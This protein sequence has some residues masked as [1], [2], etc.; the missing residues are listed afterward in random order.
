MPEW[1]AYLAIASTLALA[2]LLLSCHKS[3]GTRAAE[4]EA[5]L[6]GERARANALAG[7][8]GQLQLVQQTLAGVQAEAGKTQ[9]QLTAALSASSALDTEVRMLNTRHGEVEV[10]RDAAITDRDKALDALREE[11]LRCGRLETELRAVRGAADELRTRAEQAESDRDRA[12]DELRL[13]SVALAEMSAEAEK[14]KELAQQSRQFV[15]SAREQLTTS[16]TEAASKVFDEKAMS[17]EQRIALSGEVSKKNLEETLRPFNE[18]L[19]TFRERV[20]SLNQSQSKDNNELIGAVSQL[21][22]LNQHMATTTENL[23]R[24]LKGNAKIRGNWGEMIL[25]TVLK[26]SGLEEGVNFVR[27]ASSKDEE[28][29]QRRQPDVVLTLP[30]GRQVV[31]DSKVNLVAWS[32]AHETEDA[33]EYQQAMLRHAAAL[34]GHVKDLSEKNYPKVLGGQ[35]LDLT[36]LF[37]PIEGA[38]SQALATDANLQTDAWKLK[39]AFATPNTLMAMLQI[40]ERL[41]MRD[42]L[43]KQVGLI[44][45][46]AGKLID[47]VTSFLADFKVIDDKLKGLQIAYGNASKRLSESPQSVLERTKRLVSAGAKGKKLLPDEL[48]PEGATLPLLAGPED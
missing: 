19:K 31:I 14:A 9:A 44:G 40:V 43:Q 47:S 28:T 27:Q 21:K 8:E 38:L 35:A 42:R 7:A 33:E 18:N 23:T 5:E 32:Q 3:A 13:S 37:V 2:L 1:V 34:R 20:D 11:Q 22:S 15:E 6:A 39:V 26:T 25:E 36:V 46:E 12:R 10:E 24:A 16:F 29:G 48:V 45:D 41:W 17:L 4:L 30:D